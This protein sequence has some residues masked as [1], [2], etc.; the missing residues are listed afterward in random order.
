MNDRHLNPA[1]CRVAAVWLGLA[2]AAGGAYALWGPGGAA[3]VAG[4]L[5][6][7]GAE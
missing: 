3:L 6:F 4:V 1:G 2:L 5:L 7:K